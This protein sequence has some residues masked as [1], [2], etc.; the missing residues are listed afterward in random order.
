MLQQLD[1]PLG[2]L[3]HRL[4]D[5]LPAITTKDPHAGRSA[6]RGDQF[7]ASRLLVGQ[8]RLDLSLRRSRPES[9][10]IP[11]SLAPL[12]QSRDITLQA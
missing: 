3:I 2:H 4:R 11:E 7:D 12:R 10:E 5:E 9:N 1:I 8:A 6:I